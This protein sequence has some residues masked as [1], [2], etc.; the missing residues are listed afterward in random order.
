MKPDQ[1]SKDTKK[2]NLVIGGRP[3]SLEIQVKDETIIQS[4]AKEINDKIDSFQVMY[5]K[6]EQ[7]DCMALSLLSYAVELHK[8]KRNPG[9]PDQQQKDALSAFLTHTESLLDAILDSEA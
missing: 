8:L 5:P 6:R 3:Y 4:I 1:D 7:K 2:I 9:A